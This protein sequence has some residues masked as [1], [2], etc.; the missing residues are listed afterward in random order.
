M[1]QPTP[2]ANESEHVP[3]ALLDALA[4]AHRVLIFSGAGMSAES[5]IP[6][7]R[8]TM[9][10]L[11]AE[12]NPQELASPEGWKIDKCRVWGWYEWRR[13]LVSRAQPHAGHLAIPKLADA[14]GRVTGHTV[15]VS[16]V[17][18]NVDDLHER[19][20]C[21]DVQH[22]HG[23]LYQPRCHACD[24]AAQFLEPPPPEP[25][26]RL[27]PPKCTRC[28]GDVRPGVVWFGEDLPKAAWSKAQSLI[29]ACDVMLVVGTSGVVYPAAGLP[30]AAHQAGKRV[31][32]INPQP[33]ELS[34]KVEQYWQ[35]TAATGL[36][37]LLQKLQP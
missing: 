30:V 11:W 7:F 35:T 28:G 34:N 13:G 9:H 33:S 22:L 19:A 31:F 2:T 27:A 4:K 37:S 24:A 3:P 25:V 23:S 10:S 29:A 15:D 6:T 26:A 1:T 14:L 18:Q 21:I 20:G 17:T 5:G 8:S 12:F 32:E 16:V 36:G